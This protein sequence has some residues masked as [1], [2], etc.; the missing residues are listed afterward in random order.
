M[1]NSI[2]QIIFGEGYTLSNYERTDSP[3]L[4]PCECTIHLGAPVVPDEYMI[5][6]GCEK[7]SW[8]KV[9]GESSLPEPVARNSSIQQLQER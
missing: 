4:T 6:R 5:Y 7:G 1:P 9:K 8:A 2:I 3:L